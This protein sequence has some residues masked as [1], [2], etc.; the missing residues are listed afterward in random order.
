[1][2]TK[3]GIF[4]GGDA[5]QFAQRIHLLGIYS[6][7]KNNESSII[8]ISQ[9]EKPSQGRQALLTP[10]INSLKIKWKNQETF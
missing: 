6:R 9:M 8:S 5:E 10:E 2:N 3:T 4:V 7:N 1:M